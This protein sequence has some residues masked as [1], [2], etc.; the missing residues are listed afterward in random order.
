MYWMDSQ[1]Y[2]R[3]NIIHI[4]HTVFCF[5]VFELM[6]ILSTDVFELVTIDRPV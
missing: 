3:Y 2:G 5:V 6:L 1:V 4:L